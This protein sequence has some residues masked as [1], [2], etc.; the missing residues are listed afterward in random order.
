MTP[1][2]TPSTI[3]NQE[4]QLTRMITGKGEQWILIGETVLGGHWKL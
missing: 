1:T 4:E 2:V 3:E